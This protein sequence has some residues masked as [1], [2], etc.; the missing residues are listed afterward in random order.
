MAFKE[1][2]KLVLNLYKKEHV[3]SDQAYELISDMVTKS[4]EYEVG[5]ISL[6]NYWKNTT[7]T[8]ESFSTDQ[9]QG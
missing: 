2:I 5:G 9:E 8:D 7:T 6:S 1:N 3:N 4:M